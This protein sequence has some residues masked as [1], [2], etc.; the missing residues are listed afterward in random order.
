MATMYSSD[1]YRY[2]PNGDA[3]SY[4]YQI[5][6]D[7]FRVIGQRLELLDPHFKKCCKKAKKR[8]FT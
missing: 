1:N 8:P 7:R 6:A 4:P 3:S 2:P 5:W